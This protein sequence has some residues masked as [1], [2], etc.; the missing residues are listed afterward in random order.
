[1]LVVRS[2]T[3]PEVERTLAD[4]GVP[5]GQLVVVEQATIGHLRRVLRGFAVEHAAGQE[6]LAVPDALG[7]LV[8]GGDAAVRV[9]VT[10]AP[11]LG[12]TFPGD[13]EHVRAGI[14]VAVEAGRYP[15]SL[16]D[17]WSGSG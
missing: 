17:G 4:H 6:E 3:R 12:V 8:A 9:H 13:L 7:A 16:A 14:R 10:D 5:L 2:A 1:V 15:A 11:W